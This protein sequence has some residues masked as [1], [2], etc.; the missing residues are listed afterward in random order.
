MK[1]NPKPHEAAG[2]VPARLC[3]CVFVF[4]F[5]CVRACVDVRASAGTW[6]RSKSALGPV[7]VLR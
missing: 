2:A 1:Q 4:V 7:P 3:V 5:V 6:H